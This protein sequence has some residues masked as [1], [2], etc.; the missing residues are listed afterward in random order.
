ME[1]GDEHLHAHKDEPSTS[2]RTDVPSTSTCKDVSSASI[3]VNLDYFYML[4]AMTI[5]I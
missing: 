4:H 3:E 5:C 2:A 1:D